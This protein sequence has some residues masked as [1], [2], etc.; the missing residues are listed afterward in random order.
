[1]FSLEIWINDSLDLI[2]YVAKPT[3]KDY[4]KR[5]SRGK[6]VSEQPRLTD[7]MFTSLFIVDLFG[8]FGQN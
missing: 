2:V 3:T 5:W 6:A 4:F 7:L 8:Y 1:M